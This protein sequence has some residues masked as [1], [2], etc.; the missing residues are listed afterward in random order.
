LVKFK[1]QEKNG[2]ITNSEYKRLREFFRGALPQNAMTERVTTIN[3]RSFAN[4]VKLRYKP[5][6]QAEIRWVAKLMLDAVENSQQLPIALE[7]LRK[8]SWQI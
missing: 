3:L 8:N 6:A 5:E 4:L 2:V 7:A 1:T